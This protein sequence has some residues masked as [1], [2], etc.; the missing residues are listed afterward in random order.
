MLT[1]VQCEYCLC[2]GRGWAE[3]KLE[4]TEINRMDFWK[5]EDFM[6]EVQTL[7]LCTFI[8]LVLFFK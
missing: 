2:A 1:V 5:M 3:S 7:N 6:L 4:I 8:N